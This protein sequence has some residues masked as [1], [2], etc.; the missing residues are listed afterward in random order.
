MIMKSNID[1]LTRL[2]AWTYQRQ[3]LDQP[4]PTLETALHQIIGVYSSHP[5]APLSLSARV[6]SFNPTDFLALEQHKRAVRISA[7]RGS[8]F[9]LLVDDAATAFAALA[10]SKKLS[11]S[12]LKYQGIPPEDYPALK[13]K[14]LE[15]AQTP[16]SASKLR[17]LTGENEQ[18]LAAVARF[19]AAYE[20]EILRIGSESLRS[21]GLRYVSTRAWLPEFLE[22]RDIAESQHTIA[23]RYFAAF[24]PARA[25]D[26]QWWTGIKKAQAQQI[27]SGLNL[28]DI[29]EGLLLPESDVQAFDKIKVLP[30]DCINILPKWDSYTM[31]YAPDGR[32]R[33]VAPE[34]QLR[35]YTN[36]GDGLGT[37]LLGG[38]AVAAWSS[39]FTGN[40]LNVSLDIFEESAKPYLR[41]IEEKFGEMAPVL[42]G[43]DCKVEALESP[44]AP[45]LGMSRLRKS[46]NDV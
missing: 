12:T 3:L 34:M 18:Q 19:A 4:V 46:E 20:S 32:A 29:G 24:G 16:L 26:F 41:K 17:E 36:V 25:E 39:N 22:P 1:L 13:A 27:I 28:V 7:M 8:I 38:K 11:A 9:L 44:L 31:G 15:A 2:R 23:T 37:V 43:T 10:S 40:R 21:N 5:S 42:K 6:K 45:R 33:L 14:V 35:V 30:Q